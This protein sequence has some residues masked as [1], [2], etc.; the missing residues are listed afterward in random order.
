MLN[1]TYSREQLEKLCRRYHV[2]KLS[3]FGSRARGDERPDS[4]LDLLVE[5]EPKHMPGWEY[6]T[7]EDELAKLFKTR[8]ELATMEGLREKIR[9]QVLD[10]AKTIYLGEGSRIH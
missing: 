8:V 3:V 1:L 7:L 10:D 9:K 6:F 5:F 4:D 2:S